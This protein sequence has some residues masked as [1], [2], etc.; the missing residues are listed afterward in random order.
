MTKDRRRTKGEER[1][2]VAML[3]ELHAMEAWNADRKLKERMFPPDW[4]RLHHTTPTKPKKVRVTTG[5]DADVA[6][7]YR[8]LGQGYQAR[9]NAV[10]RAYMHAVLSKE[11]ETAADRDW[12]GDPI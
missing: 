4:R 6:R 9:M 2:Y 10:L 1:S 8:G 11:I 7:W 3:E 12:K 5:L